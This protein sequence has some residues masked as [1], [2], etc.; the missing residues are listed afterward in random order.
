M[1]YLALPTYDGRCL[2]GTYDAAVRVPCRPTSRHP[3]I[4]R[5]NDFS[6]L[7]NN[8]NTLW[9]EA[10]NG[11]KHGDCRYFVM[12]HAD[13]IPQPEWVDDLLDLIKLHDADIV[14]TIV[15]IKNSI[16]LTSTAIGDPHDPWKLVK[17]LTMSEVYDMPETFSAADIGF[18]NNPLLVNT[19]C[20]ICDLSKPWT[21]EVNDHGESKFAFNIHSR[22][23][24][25]SEG[26]FY[27]DHARP[28]DWNMSRHVWNC[29]G[30]VLATRKVKVTHFGNAGFTNAQP[31]G[32]HKVDPMAGT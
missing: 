20:W 26:L 8:F 7:P 10:L 17:R 13:I 19:G 18:P 11:Y 32:T 24:L 9:C 15:P 25:N 1:I 28:E 4:I 3:M 22:N 5:T 31:W 2:A 6:L 23:L 27:V 16:G 29:G 30:K 21:R 12:L 14:S